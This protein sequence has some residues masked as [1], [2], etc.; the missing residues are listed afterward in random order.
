MVQ[1]NIYCPKLHPNVANWSFG[2]FKWIFSA[3]CRRGNAPLPRSPN[4]GR[5]EGR[6]KGRH[7]LMRRED[8]DA[9]KG[10][11]R[12]PRRTTKTAKWLINHVSIAD[13]SLVNHSTFVVYE[14]IP[15]FDLFTSV[16][17]VLIYFNF[18]IT[19]FRYSIFSGSHVL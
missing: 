10:E 5:P 18:L 9:S 14:R 1:F 16:L 4:T 2:G 8:A 13:Q 3:G 6:A 17:N 11:V 19:Y 15:Q 12:S 7:P